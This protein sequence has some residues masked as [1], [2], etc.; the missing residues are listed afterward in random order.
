M[1]FGQTKKN[2][3]ALGQNSYT[4]GLKDNEEKYNEN[5]A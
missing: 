1:G 5:D 3:K 4:L 2:V